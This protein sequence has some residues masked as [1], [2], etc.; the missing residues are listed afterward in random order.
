MDVLPF[1]LDTG[2]VC[3]HR[4]R[5]DPAEL[6]RAQTAPAVLQTRVRLFLCRP[7]WHKLPACH[8]VLYS[9]FYML[10]PLFSQTYLSVRVWTFIYDCWTLLLIYQ[11]Y[12]LDPKTIGKICTQIIVIDKLYF[13][14]KQCALLMIQ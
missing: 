2:H 6:L 13:P 4:D 5:T 12:T 1:V 14:T 3:W 9:V 10:S 8:K 7:A 11:F